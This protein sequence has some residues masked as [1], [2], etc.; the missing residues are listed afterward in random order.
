MVHI[1][2]IYTIYTH[3]NHTHTSTRIHLMGATLDHSR[4]TNLIVPPVR[5]LFHQKNKVTPTW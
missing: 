5:H 2:H 3:H 4:G 1:S